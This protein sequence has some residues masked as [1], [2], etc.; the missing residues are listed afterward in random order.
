VLFATESPVK[1]QEYLQILEDSN[2]KI[3]PEY[4]RSC[5]VMV[6]PAESAACDIIIFDNTEIKL[7][8]DKIEICYLMETTLPIAI[9]ID[10]M[11]AMARDSDGGNDDD[12]YSMLK[13]SIA[14]FGM[15][16]KIICISNPLGPTGKFYSLY[17]NSFDDDTTLM[18]Q[19]PTWLSN[20]TISQSYLDSER[21]KDPSN[22]GMH[23]GAEFGD[24]GASPFLPQL[25]VYEAFR[26]RA[27]NI[28]AEHGNPHIR[29]FA[30]LDPAYSS[31]N[32]TLVVIHLEPIANMTNLD[33]KPLMRVIV[34]HM[35]LWRPRDSFPINPNVVD[36]YILDLAKKFKFAQISYDH[37]GSIGSI[38]KLQS[39]GLNVVKVTFSKDYQDKIFAEMYELFVNN[40]IEFYGTDT[41]IF[42]KDS[43]EASENGWYNLGEVLECRDQLINLQKK[44]RSNSTYKVEALKGKHDDFPDCVAAASY[45]ALKFKEYQR[46][47]KA[48]SIYTGPR[49]R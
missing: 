19:L 32:Y 13:P 43:I 28:R 49:F 14:T 31:D 18:F 12:L 44:W 29:Y 5:N 40:R 21:T 15:D 36:A 47:A 6:T 7:H 24:G 38:T 8:I 4:A 41:R 25:S 22:F 46:L 39:C 26:E 42:D 17:N 16:G 35:H 20:P 9:I 45:E 27:S 10:E 34:D 37:W 2:Y 3:I 48:R 30:H 1:V 11:A 33:G 23:Y